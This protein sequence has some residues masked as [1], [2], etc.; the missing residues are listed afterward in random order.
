MPSLRWAPAPVTKRRSSPILR[1]GV[2]RSGAGPGWAAAPPRGRGGSGAAHSGGRRG[3][4]P[5]GGGV[6]WRAGGDGGG[7]ANPGAA[8]PPIEAWGPHGD[9]GRR[10]IRGS[11]P[12][13]GGA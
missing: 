1:G 2:S 5:G 13:A 9:P 12:R 4:G 7:G 8:D 3:G 6:V 10:A 11:I